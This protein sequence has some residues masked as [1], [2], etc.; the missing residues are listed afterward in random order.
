MWKAN[1][2]QFVRSFSSHLIRLSKSVCSRRHIWVDV[3][4]LLLD[5]CSTL[6]LPPPRLSISSLS[7]KCLPHRLSS[8]H[9]LSS[10]CLALNTCL[11]EL[12]LWLILHPS[13]A[14]HFPHFS[15]SI[16]LILHEAPSISFLIASLTISPHNFA[17]GFSWMLIAR[18]TSFPYCAPRAKCFDAESS[19]PGVLDWW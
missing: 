15:A 8:N 17:C 5:H 16:S 9:S 10:E 3:E 6:S 13:T 12:C 2:Y 18:A 1:A 19:S 11:I 7:R 4:G 14:F